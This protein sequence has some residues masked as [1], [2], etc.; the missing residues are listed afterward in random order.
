MAAEQAP[1]PERRSISA[2]REFARRFA[3]LLHEL[4]LQPGIQRKAEV[5]LDEFA[6]AHPNLRASYL[7]RDVDES[8][9]SDG[10]C[11]WEAGARPKLQ[12]MAIEGETL[13]E[14]LAFS[15]GLRMHA[16]PLQT[17]MHVEELW[18]EPA[19]QQPFVLRCCL[20]HSFP[21]TT[22]LCAST[23]ESQEALHNFLVRLKYL[24]GF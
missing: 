5:L 11:G 13:F 6:D 12:A 9:F 18:L 19:P 16:T 20:Y 14:F 17:V 1:V 24:R 7:S 15:Q 10:A 4:R 22:L 23:G 3:N 2:G 21:A 8:Y